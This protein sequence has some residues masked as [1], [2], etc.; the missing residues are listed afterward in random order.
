MLV[1]KFLCDVNDKS[2]RIGL[3][4]LVMSYL[5]Q[6][7]DPW[8][9]Q[10]VTI[11]HIVIGLML[12]IHSFIHLRYLYGIIEF[13]T[14]KLYWRSEMEKIHIKLYTHLQTQESEGDLI[15]YDFYKFSKCTCL[16]A[17]RTSCLWLKWRKRSCREPDTRAG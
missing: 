7:R 10:V 1:H 4:L 5:G 9:S 17:C 12:H 8:Y 15:I 13:Y 14:T 11:A 6:I 2:S 16:K 3:C